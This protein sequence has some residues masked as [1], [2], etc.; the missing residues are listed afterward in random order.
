MAGEFTIV[1]AQRFCSLR[2]EKELTKF[3]ALALEKESVCWGRSRGADLIEGCTKPR[4]QKVVLV[5][6]KKYL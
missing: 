6:L 5:V 4:S 3:N 2:L 1:V